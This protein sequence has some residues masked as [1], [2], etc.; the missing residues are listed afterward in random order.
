MAVNNIKR[1]LIGLPYFV[2]AVLDI[3]PRQFSDEE[4]RHF[5]YRLGRSGVDYLR[6]FPFWEGLKPYRKRPSGKY[7]LDLWNPLY[8]DKLRRVCEAAYQWKISIYFDLF[9]HCYTKPPTREDNPWYNNTQTANTTRFTIDGIY[10]TDVVSLDYYKRWIKKVW[11]TVGKRG[12]F[13][14]KNGST[15]RLRPNLYGLG[16]ELHATWANKKEREK[17]GYKWGYGLA[18]YLWRLGYRREILWS[19][20][21]ET[22]HTL[23]A[24]LDSSDPWVRKYVPDCPFDKKD[25]VYQYHGWISRMVPDDVQE[26]VEGTDKRKIAYSDDGVNFPWGGDGICIEQ[27][28]K[29][30]YCSAETQ[31]VI[32][33]CRYIH[34]NL[35]RAYQFHHIEQLPRSV[36]E[37]YHSLDDLDKHR[38]ENIYRRIAKQVWGVDITRT[39]PRWL[40]ERYGIKE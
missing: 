30:K 14:R 11:D 16:N 13:T 3:V 2:C 35:P 8:F 12:Y 7:D 31:S 36:S 23:R 28:G 6:I 15:R 19:A 26:I 37:V 17:F 1:K 40:K 18:E 39:Y 25:T 38:D 29:Q 33:L 9:D 22:G 24:Y 32:R 21:R 20:E 27:D 34:E 5:F 4:L 10:Q